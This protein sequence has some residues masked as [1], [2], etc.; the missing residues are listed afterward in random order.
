[1]TAVRKERLL[2]GGVLVITRILA[3]GRLMSRL[4]PAN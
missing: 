4:Q 3:I 1:V 2:F